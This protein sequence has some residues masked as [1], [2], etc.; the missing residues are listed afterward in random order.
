[1][2]V[3][4]TL[5]SFLFLALVAG[6]LAADT[7][8]ALFLEDADPGAHLDAAGRIFTTLN[9]KDSFYR[10]WTRIPGGR[11]GITLSHWPGTMAGANYNFAGAVF[12]IPN[13]GSFSVN[14][15]SYSAGEETINEF[16]GTSRTV[17]L[18]ENTLVGMGYGKS[19][20]HR[21]SAGA[22]LKYL[23]STLAEN[24]SAGALVGDLGAMYRFP[25]GIH[26]AGIALRN[27]GQS[28]TYYKTA[29]P[30]PAQIDAGYAARLGVDSSVVLG[31]TYTRMLNIDRQTVSAGAVWNPGDVPYLSLIGGIRWVDTN[32]IYTIGLGL[33]YGN[34][35]GDIGY[36]FTDVV[37]SGSAPLRFSL[38]WSWGGREEETVPENRYRRAGFY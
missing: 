17:K 22:N 7:P 24:Y 27:F 19:F 8:V 4:R 37:I 35:D 25:A 10:P 9:F 14:Y 2:N 18:E 34:F 1:M 20:S 26:H 32:M 16:D 38:N 12:S 11:S 15:L 6:H 13:A 33:R 28:L 21:W 29:E 30:L 31:A 3:R 36:R 23:K 5:I